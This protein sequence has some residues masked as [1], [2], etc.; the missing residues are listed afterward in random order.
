MIVFYAGSKKEEFPESMFIGVMM[1]AFFG[2]LPLFLCLCCVCFRA[3]RVR[4][5]PPN[6]SGFIPVSGSGRQHARIAGAYPPGEFPPTIHITGAHPPKYPTVPSANRQAAEPIAP[7]PY[8][9][10]TDNRMKPPDYEDIAGISSKE[11]N[12]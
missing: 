12:S 3:R 5:Q 9:E 8:E 7:P 10:C 6:L 11:N 4:T 1:T 2:F